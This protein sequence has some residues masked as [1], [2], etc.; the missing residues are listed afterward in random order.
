M[1]RGG[2]VYVKRDM[3]NHDEPLTFAKE[4]KNPLMPWCQWAVEAMRAPADQPLSAPPSGPRPKGISAHHRA[5]VRNL[6]LGA[7]SQAGQRPVAWWNALAAGYEPFLGS[8]FEGINGDPYASVFDSWLQ[9][10]MK[11][12]DK[13]ESGWIEWAT[14][15]VGSLADR[16]VFSL[17]FPCKTIIEPWEETPGQ[18]M[19]S[20]VLDNWWSSAFAPAIPSSAGKH[21][22]KV[23]LPRVADWTRSQFDR[24][25][26]LVQA[27]DGK[28]R[29]FSSDLGLP[30]H[31]MVAAR[32]C[33][34]CLPL[35]PR[36]A[37]EDM[38]KLPPIHSHVSFLKPA[39]ITGWMGVA[40]WAMARF[41]RR[42]QGARA[43]DEAEWERTVK[44]VENDIHQRTPDTVRL[45]SPFE[46]VLQ[47]TL[48]APG[49]TLADEARQ[50]DISAWALRM[51]TVKTPVARTGTGQRRL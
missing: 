35:T 41:C 8:P 37:L 18:W 24:W 43:W 19:Y 40:E 3:S 15:T 21:A 29:S 28:M 2:M 44:I 11:S 9:A 25:T 31:W 33:Q 51:A 42:L 7:L 6:F 36:V 23:N 5:E 10:G 16:K 50:A 26:G 20:G 48:A 14:A 12:S 47:Y 22:P 38:G 17:V 30:W 32:Q 34:A 27:I 39:P 4:A 45:L 13:A 49:L 46:K 1:S